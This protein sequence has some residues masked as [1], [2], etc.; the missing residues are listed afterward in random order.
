[1]GARS[2]IE[3]GTGQNTASVKGYWIVR[4][5]AKRSPPC[6]AAS[7]SQTTITAAF[8][9]KD[10]ATAQRWLILTGNEAKN[11]ADGGANSSVDKIMEDSFKLHLYPNPVK[12]GQ[13]IFPGNEKLTEKT[14]IE[15]VNVAGKT[16]LQFSG[17]KP[18]YAP[19][20]KGVYILILKFT[21]RQKTAVCK[22]MVE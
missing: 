22:L 17:D 4:P 14:V 10:S 2:N 21:T 16:V 3:T 6:L 8:D 7:A 9:I 12:P 5:E 18:I 1:M 19:Q 20:T 15:I 11:T 13:Q